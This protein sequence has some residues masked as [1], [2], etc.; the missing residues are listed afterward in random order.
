MR[1]ELVSVIYSHSSY[2]DVLDI[3]L[4]QFPGDTLVAA[5]KPVDG[6]ETLIYDESLTYSE[7]LIQVL[8]QISQEWVLYTH[9]DHILYGDV[10]W[11]LIYSLSRPKADFIK[12][13]RTGRLKAQIHSPRLFQLDNRSPDI[14]AVQPTIWRRES[15]IS[16]LKKAGP[17]SIWDLEIK[18]PEFIGDL[19]G[20]LYWT[21]KEKQRG[22]HYDSLIYPCVLT[23]ICKGKWNV[24]EY[25]PELAEIFEKY[26]VDS[27]IRGVV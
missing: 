10:D 15:F 3:C 20:W 8:E 19:R 1:M 16:F 14:F 23:A 6:I 2:F 5:D 27:S 26:G 9:E 18:G 25:G 22:G 21:S 7:R 12:L 4:K 13:C 17:N 24:S 11:E